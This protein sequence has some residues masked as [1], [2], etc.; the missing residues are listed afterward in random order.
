MQAQEGGEAPLPFTSLMVLEFVSEIY[1]VIENGNPIKRKDWYSGI[2]PL[3]KL[4]GD[5]N[6]PP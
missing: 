5:E 4:L 2:E 1:Q 6:V 3:F